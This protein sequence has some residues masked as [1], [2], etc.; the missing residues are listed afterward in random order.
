MRAEREEF[1]R[2]WAE[3][4]LLLRTC[5]AC[6]A[7]RLYAAPF[8]DACGSREHRALPAS[9]SGEIHSFTVVPKRDAPPRT[10]VLVTLAEG[11]RVLGSLEGGDEPAIGG[12]VIIA[13]DGS[14]AGPIRFRRMS[15]GSASE[16]PR[17]GSA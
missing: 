3:G 9:G 17:R 4:I 16:R 11:A 15:A 6:G 5:T 2:S 13:P 7:R 1:W 10:V 14:A 12:R 8:C